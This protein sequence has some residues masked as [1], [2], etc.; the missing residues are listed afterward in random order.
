MALPVILAFMARM[1]IIHGGKKAIQMAVKKFG[2]KAFEKATTKMSY[3]G[4]SAAKKVKPKT[5][6]DTKIHKQTS[7]IRKRLGMKKP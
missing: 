5:Y 6:K 1:G 3:A 4:R 7:R 2:K